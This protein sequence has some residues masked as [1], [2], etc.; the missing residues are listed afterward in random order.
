MKNALLT[1]ARK[2]QL[3]DSLLQL[4]RHYCL[5]LHI[6][7]VV[8][9]W[10]SGAATLVMQCCGNNASSACNTQGDVDMCCCSSSTF[11]AKVG[12]GER[13][14][15]GGGGGGESRELERKRKTQR[16][17]DRQRKRPTETKTDRDR[18]KERH[19]DGN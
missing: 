5:S 7:I 17:T 12:E 4:T 16:E 18:D 9:C 8:L 2:V 14:R 11:S 10:V 6:S 15:G 13:G 1:R 19:R 3:V